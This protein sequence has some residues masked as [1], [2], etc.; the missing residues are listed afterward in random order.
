MKS[1]RGEKR[2]GFPHL[3]S[4]GEAEAGGEGGAG[5]PAEEA[6]ERGEGASAAVEEEV[7]G[8]VD[9]GAG[10][11]G[12]RGGGGEVEEEERGEEDGPDEER[13]D[14]DVDG[15]AVV[16]AVEG[17]VVLQVEEAAAAAAAARL[18][19]G[20][21]CSGGSF[22]VR[23]TRVSIWPGVGTG[24]CELL[25]LRCRRCLWAEWG[26]GAHGWRGGY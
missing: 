10:G 1:K 24:R 9:G 26:C 3:P 22:Q 18:R 6:E 14:E 12:V 21:V 5:G 20:C 15:V 16:R 11:R 19:H 8:P 2:K 23:T 17:E 7:E 13:V 4:G 25:Q